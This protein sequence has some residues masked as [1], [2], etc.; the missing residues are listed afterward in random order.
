MDT[1]EEM[2]GDSEEEMEGDSSFF[3][4]NLMD[5]LVPQDTHDHQVKNSTGVYVHKVSDLN[6]VLRFLCVGNEN[7]SYYAKQKELDRET[8][9]SIDR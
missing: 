6:R 8:V 2:E 1:E 4:H 3:D 5:S 9:Q 7:G